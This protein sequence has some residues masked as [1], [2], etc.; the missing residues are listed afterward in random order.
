MQ[1]NDTVKCWHCEQCDCLYA[2]RDFAW[3]PFLCETQ[4]MMRLPQDDVCEQFVL[5]K[6]LHTNKRYP[7]KP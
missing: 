5:R 1:K 4:R 2:E 3:Q 6:G 7:G